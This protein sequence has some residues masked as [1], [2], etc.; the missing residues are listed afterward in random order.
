[1]DVQRA[2]Q[3]RL[4][5]D[6]KV[7]GSYQRDWSARVRYFERTLSECQTLEQSLYHTEMTLRN[8]ALERSPTL[9]VIAV[10]LSSAA[11]WL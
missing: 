7:S 4:I 11:C 9:P 6:G 3:N 5:P 10:A 2:R 1:M 8:C